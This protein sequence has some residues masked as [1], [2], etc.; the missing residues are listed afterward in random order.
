MAS[1]NDALL[2]KLWDTHKLDVLSSIVTHLGV[3]LPP[4]AKEA[5]PMIRNQKLDS[6]VGKQV[7]LQMT[8][9]SNSC[10]LYGF[11][12]SV[13]RCAK[14]LRLTMKEGSVTFPKSTLWLPR[15]IFRWNVQMENIM[16]MFSAE[17]FST[18]PNLALTLGDEERTRLMSHKGKHEEPAAAAVGSDVARL[19]HHF[20]TCKHWAAVL[21]FHANNLMSLNII[22]EWLE[23][24][25]NKEKQHRAFGLFRQVLNTRRQVLGF[26]A[27]RSFTNWGYSK[28]SQGPT[29][30]LCPKKSVSLSV[31]PPV[32][33]T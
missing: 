18:C 27:I 16:L 19:Q 25:N 23:D 12:E 10:I 21:N 4:N 14:G 7:L 31:I 3:P 29:S 26:P 1:K 13:S 8:E 30:P 5:T 6:M 20:P 32:E 17:M 2:I 9:N 28:M 24:R 22:S 33:G 15:G 11:L